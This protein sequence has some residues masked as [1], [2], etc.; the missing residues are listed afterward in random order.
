MSELNRNT[1]SAFKKAVTE[2]VPSTRANEKAPPYAFGD[3]EKWIDFIDM[4][5]AEDVNAIWRDRDIWSTD[6]N[7]LTR[8]REALAEVNGRFLCRDN[9]LEMMLACALAQANMVFLGSPGLLLN[10]I[11]DFRQC[12]SVF[13]GFSGY[14]M[15][16]A[17]RSHT[18]A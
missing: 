11:L 16:L 13:Y 1:Y 4:L 15:V 17:R 6:S 3:D 5:D 7:P 10:N 14:P 2:P 12:W 9:A 8:L 18:P